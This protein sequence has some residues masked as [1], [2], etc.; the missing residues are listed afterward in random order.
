MELILE[1]T[2]GNTFHYIQLLEHPEWHKLLEYSPI[3]YC[4]TWNINRIWYETMVF[5]PSIPTS[6]QSVEIVCFFGVS[7]SWQQTLHCHSS[8]CLSG[9]WKQQET[10]EKRT[11][12]V[13]WGASSYFWNVLLNDWLLEKGTKKNLKITHDIVRKAVML[14]LIVK[15][16]ERL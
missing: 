2:A 11:Y 16:L 12:L 10:W 5:C 1:R 13:E 8:C 3:H 9:N 4:W 14:Y 15:P 6:C 7:I